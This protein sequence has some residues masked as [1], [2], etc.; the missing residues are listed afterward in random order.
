MGRDDY[1]PS[2]FLGQCSVHSTLFRIRITLNLSWT[3]KDTVI[4]L[5]LDLSEIHQDLQNNLQHFSR[6]KALLNVDGYELIF[7]TESLKLIFFV[8]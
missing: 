3:K 1:M 8:T 4:I 5:G 6:S 2:V 7:L